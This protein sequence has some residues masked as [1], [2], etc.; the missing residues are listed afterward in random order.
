ME[1]EQHSAVGREIAAKHEA[2]L[3]LGD[4]THNLCVND[5][6]VREGDRDAAQVRA[7]VGLRIRAAWPS[8]AAAISN[9]A[10]TAEAAPSQSI[11]IDLIRALCR[12][13]R[14]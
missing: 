1:V 11:E 10:I 13:H 4:G 12:E 7:G 14:R 6:A 8:P 5:G 9:T 2:T 3:L